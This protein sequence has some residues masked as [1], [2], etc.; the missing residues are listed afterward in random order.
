MIRY[1][2]QHVK[3]W[4]SQER[5]QHCYLHRTAHPEAELNAWD[6]SILWYHLLLQGKYVNSHHYPGH[7][8][9]VLE[10]LIITINDL[11]KQYQI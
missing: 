6:R 5:V 4:F 2:D 3:V 1:L 11:H 8:G 7:T 10:E 9:A